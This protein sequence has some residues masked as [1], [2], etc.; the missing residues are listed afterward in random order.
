MQKR[1]LYVNNP[2]L[3]NEAT[4]RVQNWACGADVLVDKASLLTR[5]RSNVA[6]LDAFV[7]E[8]CA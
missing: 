6:L 4:I 3:N 7:F 1:F 2:S 8:L 5:R